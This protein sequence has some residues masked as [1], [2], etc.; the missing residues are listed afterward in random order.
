MHVRQRLRNQKHV[1][2]LWE[3]LKFAVHAEANR[4]FWTWQGAYSTFTVITRSIWVRITAFI[5]LIITEAADA[6]ANSDVQGSGV[7][8]SVNLK[9]M[10]ALT[11]AK[12]QQHVAVHS[13]PFF[14]AIARA[15]MQG[16]GAFRHK[17]CKAVPSN[18]QNK[19][20]PCADIKPANVLLMEEGRAKIADV[21]LARVMED[22]CLPHAAMGQSSHTFQLHEAHAKHCKDYVTLQQKYIEVSLPINSE[23][24]SMHKESISMTL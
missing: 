6:I 2:I 20:L 13:L 3:A 23:V 21:G 5:M 15:K 7:L 9:C 11:F 14:C 10:P 19:H 22:G 8:Y 16:H 17:T 24:W 4:F 18:V 1:V 12:P